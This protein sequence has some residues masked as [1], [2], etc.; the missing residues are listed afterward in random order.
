MEQRI[1]NPGENYEGLDEWMKDNEHTPSME[2]QK[3]T[4]TERELFSSDK[5]NMTY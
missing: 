2:T 3:L 4:A 1:I 5:D